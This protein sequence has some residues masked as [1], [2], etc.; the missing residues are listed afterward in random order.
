MLE[1]S[2]DGV[3]SLTAGSA[4]QVC[5]QRHHTHGFGFI[6]GS[7]RPVVVRSVSA[8]G[9]SD[10]KLL[11]GDQILAINGEPVHD[12]VRERVIDLVSAAK[13][14]RLRTNPPK[15]RFSEQ[16]SISDPDS[17][18]STPPTPTSSSFPYNHPSHTSNDE[19][20]SERASE[21]DKQHTLGVPPL[22]F[23]KAT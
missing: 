4:R 7:E 23:S 5:I 3:N 13:K 8:D 6:A 10:G 20:A 22:Q 18:P 17:S 2:R 15:V 21:R 1:E 12:V 19:R 14:A 11:P 9:P 16:V